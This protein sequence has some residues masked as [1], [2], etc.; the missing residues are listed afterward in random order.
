M[1]SIRI[2]STNV[3]TTTLQTIQTSLDLLNIEIT[4]TTGPVKT[5]L[6]TAVPQNAVGV[7]QMMLVL[8][9]LPLFL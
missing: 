4:T 6:P 3:P 2:S 1:A 8:L 7:M 5:A 9:M